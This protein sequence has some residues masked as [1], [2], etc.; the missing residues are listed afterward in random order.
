MAW[1]F[2]PDWSH[3]STAATSLLVG[4]LSRS[5]KKKQFS[6]I[7]AFGKFS[8][9]LNIDPGDLLTKISTWEISFNSLNHK[10]CEIGTWGSRVGKNLQSIGNNLTGS[11][12]CKVIVRKFV[13]P[14]EN[15]DWLRWTMFA[16][17]PRWSILDNTW[18]LGILCLTWL[19][20]RF[21]TS[22]RSRLRY[23]QLNLQSMEVKLTLE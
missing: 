12:I 19:L 9:T 23:L 7:T 13:R 20:G 3:S 6:E 4:K 17:H 10:M 15:I 2:F 14:L 16:E 18:L 8:L 22:Q 1:S 21:R 5:L 11:P